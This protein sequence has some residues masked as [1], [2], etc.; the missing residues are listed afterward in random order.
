[1]KSKDLRDVVISHFS[2]GKKPAE[3]EK[4]MNKKVHISTICRWINVFR[5]N[6]GKVPGYSSGRPKTARTKRLITQVKNRLNSRNS[7][8]SVR[9][10]AN[11]FGSNRETVRRVLKDL[12]KRPYRKIKVQRLNIGQDVKR[13]RCCTFGRIFLLVELEKLCLPTKKFS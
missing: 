6:G 9:T 2:N 12:G 10:M 5:E 3:I 4:M 13:K 11:D 7:R 8:K 1:M